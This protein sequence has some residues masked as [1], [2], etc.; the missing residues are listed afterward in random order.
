[1]PRRFRNH[2]P[3]VGCRGH[4]TFTS[5]ISLLGSRILFFQMEPEYRTVKTS[6]GSEQTTTARYPVIFGAL[7]VGAGVILGVG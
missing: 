4:L 1:M 5:T 6:T 3:D 7:P 2:N